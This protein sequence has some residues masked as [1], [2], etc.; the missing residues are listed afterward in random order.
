MEAMTRLMP[1]NFEAKFSDSVLTETLLRSLLEPY[2]NSQGLWIAIPDTRTNGTGAILTINLSVWPAAIQPLMR[3]VL[4]QQGGV[5]LE[6]PIEMTVLDG[7]PTVRQVKNLDTSL[8]VSIAEPAT[9]TDGPP[10]SPAS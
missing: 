2:R 5:P 10:S 8:H 1:S 4:E 6:S 9:D 7:K 3:S